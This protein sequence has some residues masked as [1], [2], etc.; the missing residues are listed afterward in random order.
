MRTSPAAD[1]GNS[2]AIVHTD[3]QR[4][5]MPALAL[6]AIG[7]VFGDIGTSPLYT[8]STVFDASNGL[9]LNPVNL[10]GV[11]SLILW[12]LLIVV[13]GARRCS[14]R[15]RTTSGTWPST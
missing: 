14:R 11:V 8:M 10:I 6:A 15:C 7:I 4:R 9:V 1:A 12:S 3:F 5:S 13:C 2:P